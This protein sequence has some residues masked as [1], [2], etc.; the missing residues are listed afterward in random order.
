MEQR[1]IIVKM[2]YTFGESYVETFRKVRGIFGLRNVPYQSKVQR[3]TKKCG[4]RSSITD[5]KLPV[6]NLSLL[7]IC[8]V[9]LIV[10]I[11]KLRLDLYL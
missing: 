7:V 2:Y 3:M 1:V 6:L 5:S 11:I 4:K 8:I 10:Y 9:N